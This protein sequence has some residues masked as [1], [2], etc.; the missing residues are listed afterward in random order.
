MSKLHRLAFTFKEQLLGRSSSQILQE[1]NDSQFWP[2][3]KMRNHQEGLLSSVLDVAFKDSP[4]Y[5]ELYGEKGITRSDIKTIEDLKCLPILTKELFI[6]NSD[7]MLAMGFPPI[8]TFLCR[9][10]GSTGQRLVFKRDKSVGSFHMANQLR[11]RSWQGVYPGDTEIKFWGTAWN[12]ED[13]AKGKL[14]AYLRWLKDRAMGVL[15]L[16]AFAVKEKDLEK[17]YKKFIKIRPRVL[18]GYGTAIYMFAEFIKRH[19]GKAP[20]DILKVVIFTSEYLSNGRRLMIGEV[21]NCP[22]VSEYGSVEC[23]IHSYQ[24]REGNDHFSDE[25]LLFEVVDSDGYPITDGHGTLLLTHLREKATPIIRYQI[26]DIA[27]IKNSGESDCNCGMTLSVL[28]E[29]R[30]RENDLIRS[31]DGDYIHPEVFDYIMRYQP[32]IKK[33]RVIEEA[34]G[35]LH[36]MLEVSEPVSVS[37]IDALLIKLNEHVSN[38]FDFSIEQTNSILNEPSGKFRWVISKV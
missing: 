22:V 3:E 7:K 25:T 27:S 12:F 13:T 26:G 4:F 34:I 31:P 17:A 29:I 2:R 28:D 15:H 35:K 37:G 14:T 11:G 8:K 33:F 1:L 20:D 23:G 24:C 36:I 21:F 16:S 30:G 6:N 5:R 9:T 10:S 18:F 19:Y 32:G 38:E